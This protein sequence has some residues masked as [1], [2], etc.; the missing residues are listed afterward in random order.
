[1]AQMAFG[2]IKRLNVIQSKVFPTAYHSNENML[3]CAPTGAGKT[4][5]AMLTIVREVMN[6]IEDGILKLNSF[7]VNKNFIEY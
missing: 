5:V 1:M 3:I 4:N 7:K 2:G 6:N